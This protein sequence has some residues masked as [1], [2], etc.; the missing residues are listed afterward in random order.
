MIFRASHKRI[1][2]LQLLQSASLINNVIGCRRREGSDTC[3]SIHISRSFSSS[4]SSSS[5]CFALHRLGSKQFHMVMVVNMGD[6]TAQVVTAQYATL[7][8]NTT[9]IVV[10]VVVI[11]FMIASRCGGH[12]AFQPMH[13]SFQLDK[14]W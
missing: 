11:V 12:D 4:S 8:R 5:V 7:I 13:D 1:F 14:R 3:T 9:I 2:V 10:L 6:N